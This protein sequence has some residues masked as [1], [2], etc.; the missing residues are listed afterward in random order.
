MEAYSAVPADDPFANSRAMF[1]ALAAGLAGP[2]A[3]GMTAFEL[4]EFVDERGREIMRQLLQD[5]YDLRAVWEA[6]KASPP[7][8]S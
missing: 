1:T 6:V 7:S 2:A 3:A 4:E 5:H 8:W